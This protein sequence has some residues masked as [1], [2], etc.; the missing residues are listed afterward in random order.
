MNKRKKIK[1]R[2]VAKGFQEEQNPQSDSPTILRDD[3][4]LFLTVASNSDFLLASMD[5]T[6]AF[7][8]GENFDRDV[9]VEPPKDVLME[10]PGVL[11]K[12][13]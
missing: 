8:Q 7:L 5:I 9:F 2:L 12:L 13:S 1:A 6:G 4:K 11:W 3:M 10:T